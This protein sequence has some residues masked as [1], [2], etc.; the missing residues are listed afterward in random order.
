MPQ[1]VL[2]EINNLKIQIK[3]PSEIFQPVDGVNLTIHRGEIVALVG[4]SGCGKSITALAISRLLPNNAM[5]CRGSEILFENLPIHTL[6]EKK[7]QAIRGKKIAMIFQDPALALNPV[8][9][10]GDQLCESLKTHRSQ[11]KFRAI[12]AQAIR[13]LEQVKIP[14]PSE[15]FDQ[16]PHALSGGMK[17]RVMIA[18]ALSHSP[19]ILIADEPTTALDATT[20]RE[21]LQLISQLSQQYNM[22][23]LLISHDLALVGHMAD[24]VAVMYAGHIVELAAKDT[25][26]KHPK[27]PYSQ[28]LFAAIPDIT[29]RHLPL[30]TIPGEVPELNQ[31]FS[32]CRFRGRCQYIF[33][34]C[35]ITPPK[36]VCTNGQK[37]RCHWYDKQILDALPTDL[38][39][40]NISLK[41]Q[42][43]EIEPIVAATP[44]LGK[45]ILAIKNLK[46]YYPIQKG[47]FKRIVGH[48]PAV[49]DISIDLHEGQTL[50]IVGESGCGKTTLAKTV[51]RLLTP[52]QGEITFD[53]Q[54]LLS[55][56]GQKLREK[57]SDFQM[58]FQDPYASMDPRMQVDEIIEEGMIALNIG[59]DVQERQDRVDHHLLQVGLSTALRFRYIHE[60]SG[61][62]CQRV[63]IARALAVGA[64]MIV[65]DEPTS[66]LDVSVQAQVLNLLKSLQ[67]DL[68]IS[69]LF[70][71]HNMGVVGYLADWVAVM[72]FG[73]IV[74]YGPVEKILLK[75]EHPY[76][77]RL[78]AAAPTLALSLTNHG[79]F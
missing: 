14:K 11:E 47:V 78:L 7:M 56:H 59:T 24:T 19:D 15:C 64:K 28:K 45:P 39:I 76:T 66:A 65:C 8:L 71:T 54:D 40:E 55:L 35:E 16:F 25:F 60:L 20:Q 77:Q 63:A 23:V 22:A 18:M 43:P 33:K 44:I 29:Y 4:E 46:S 21:V 62:Q 73:K 49:D 2:L 36:L 53:D 48:V 13:L 17:Q 30:A 75:P 79:N 74:E 69:Y 32:L 68:A 72:Y 67:E 38:R 27:H 58:V 57:R 3:A 31:A 37:V 1:E 51:M 26:F 41:T 42:K 5:I 9:S 34:P 10:V 61:G 50:A 52:Q 6:S 70:I 12:K